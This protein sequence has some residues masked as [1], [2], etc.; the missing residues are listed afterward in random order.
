VSPEDY[1]VE[2]GL[3]QQLD[4]CLDHLA[5]VTATAGGSS[6]RVVELAAFVTDADGRA[7][8]DKVVSSRLGRLP[9]LLRFEPV[10]DVALHGL[11]ELDW[12]VSLDDEIPLE[13]AAEIIEPFGDLVSGEDLMQ[14]GPFAFLNGVYGAGN[15]MTA[16]SEDAF[17][18]LSDRLATIGSGLDQIIKMAVY[19]DSF[20][21]YPE[22]N[23]VTQRLFTS[24][25]LPTRSVVV[26]P[27]QAV[28]AI[29][30]DAVAQP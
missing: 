5:A 16:A 1:Q 20:E 2:G 21:R 14:R 9:P 22:F 7:T 23:A 18:Q 26:A 19:V 30:I 29:R 13:R 8:V 3:E 27:A 15:D 28:G 10:E 12:V 17:R 25:P 24:V 6:D 11:V 4:L